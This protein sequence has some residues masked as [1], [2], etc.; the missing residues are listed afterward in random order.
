MVGRQILMIATQGSVM[1]RMAEF[2]IVSREG[3]RGSV[4][5]HQVQVEAIVNQQDRSAGSNVFM[6]K[7]RIMPVMQTLSTVYGQ[8]RRNG[9]TPVE[10]RANPVV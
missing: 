8:L 5:V 1:T 2:V 4:V 10:K 3:H 7:I 6:L 9:K